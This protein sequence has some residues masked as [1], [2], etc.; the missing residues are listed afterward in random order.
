MTWL[1]KQGKANWFSVGSKVETR[2]A[3]AQ[4]LLWWKGGNRDLV[5]V[6]GLPN[7]LGVIIWGTVN[8]TTIWPVVVAIFCCGSKF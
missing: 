1:P 7:D 3:P 2:P 6:T 4:E 8:F 5:G